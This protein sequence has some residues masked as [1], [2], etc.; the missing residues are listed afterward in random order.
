ML[1]ADNDRFRVWNPR[2]VLLHYRLAISSGPAEYIHHNRWSS[3]WNEVNPHEDWFLHNEAGGRHHDSASNWDLNDPTS[4]A[5]RDYWVTSVIADMRATGAQG[6]FADSF[7]AGVSGYGITPPDA[8]FGGTAP[9]DPRAWPAGKT[10]A[11][12]K[13]EF[14]DDVMRRFAETPEKFMYVANL[15]DLTTSWWWP[16]YPH[17]DG[18]MLEGFALEA[19][20]EDWT[21]AMNRALELTRPGQF[22]II[23]AYP[24]TVQDRLFLVGSYLL[25]KGQHTFVNAAGSGVHYF[26]EY[27]LPLGPATDPLPVDVSAYA[28]NGVFKRE[29]QRA[30]VLVNPS[31]APVTVTLPQPFAVVTPV[32]GGV[33]GDAQLDAQLRY[34]GG[35]LTY[36]DVASVTLPSRSAAL[37]RRK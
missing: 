21:V 13:S 8:R 3:D 36:A 33:T 11:V 30:V 17:L 1:K 34:I 24:R 32:G 22:V 25:I 7:E 6:V 5:F 20:P 12:Q 15:G 4:A 19:T 37:L 27:D 14:A 18:A 10:W 28:W 29:F 23:Q 2:W 26:P 16:H 9:A 31:A 35:S